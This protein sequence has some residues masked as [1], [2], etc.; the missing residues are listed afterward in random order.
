MKTRFAVII[1]STLAVSLLMTL[2]SAPGLER[3]KLKEIVSYE[4][5]IEAVVIIPNGEELTVEEGDT[6]PDD[7]GQVAEINERIITIKK[8]SPDGKGNTIYQLSFPTK[9]RS[10]RID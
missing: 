2:K 4:D 8:P 10:L 5:G 3:L 1:V 9:P 6:L 7:L